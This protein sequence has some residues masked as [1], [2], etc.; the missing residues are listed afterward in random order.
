MMN[1]ALTRAY[2]KFEQMKENGMK[3]LIEINPDEVAE[4]VELSTAPVRIK[5]FIIEGF[6][7][8]LTNGQCLII[9]EN[10]YNKVMSS[11][12]WALEEEGVVSLLHLD[13]AY[14]NQYF[15]LKTDELPHYRETIQREMEEEVQLN[16][17]YQFLAPFEENG[18]TLAYLLEEEKSMVEEMD[19]FSDVEMS[20]KVHCIKIKEVVERFINLEENGGAYVLKKRRVYK[21][22]D[23]QLFAEQFSFSNVETAVLI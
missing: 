23:N 7:L 19:A 1:Q 18:H 9:K 8:T 22:E 3:L 6:V 10:V 11:F 5:S 2:R 14:P 15:F 20:Q 16:S 21:T 12:K 13:M 4:V 17:R